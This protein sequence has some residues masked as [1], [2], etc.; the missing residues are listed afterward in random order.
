MPALR[1][2]AK[3]MVVRDHLLSLIEGGLEAGAPV[4]SERELCQT[5]GVSR[6]TVRQAIDTLVVDGILERQQGRAP[7]WRPPNSTCS[8]G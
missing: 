3:Y 7:S 4:P 5:F 8:C 2:P 1:P 6:M